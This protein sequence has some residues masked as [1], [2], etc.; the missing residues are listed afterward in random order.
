MAKSEMD[1]ITEEK[2][3]AGGILAKFYFDIQNEE[4]DIHSRTCYIIL[5]FFYRLLYCSIAVYNP[6]LL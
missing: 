6:R 2:I 4:K 1:R 5:V 3:A